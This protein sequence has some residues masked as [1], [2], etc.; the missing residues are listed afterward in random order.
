MANLVVEVLQVDGRRGH[1]SPQR[2]DRRPPTRSRRPRRAGARSWTSSPRRWGPRTVGAERGL[3]GDRAGRPGGGRRVGVHLPHVGGCRPRD[4]QRQPD[5]RAPRPRRSA[6]GRPMMRYASA[7]IARTGHH[8]VD[9]RAAGLENVLLG[10][11]HDDARPRRARSHPTA[12]WNAGT[13]A[14]D[15]RSGSTGARICAKQ[16]IEQY[17]QLAASDPPATRCRPGRPD[18]VARSDRLG[19]DAQALTSACAPALAP[20]S[21]QTSRPRRSASASARV[22]GEA[23][24]ALSF[25]ASYGTGGAIPP[26]PVPTTTPSRPGRS[27]GCRRR[28]TP[29][30]PPPERTGSGPGAGLQRP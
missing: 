23:G 14:P 8:G 22:A 29:R 17:V 16:A 19:A 30:G 4:S 21:I 20:S 11:Q 24:P 10:L 27:Q 9:L 2:Q 18:H 3:G 5:S 13:P 26:M 25:S 28:P 15:R 6:Q 7:A 12:C 1:R